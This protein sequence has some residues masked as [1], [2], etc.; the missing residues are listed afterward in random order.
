MIARQ[1]I[2]PDFITVQELWD[3]REGLLKGFEKFEPDILTG[4][5]GL[6]RI[7]R[8]RFG[9][10][11]VLQGDSS[12]NLSLL[13]CVKATMP[14]PLGPDSDVICVDGG[15]I[16]DAYLISKHSIEQGLDSEK[17]LERIHLS[18][19]FT[20][21]QLTLLLTEKLPSAMDVY[22]AKL[23]IVSDMA[24][25]YCDPDIRGAD[26]LDALRIFTNTVR[27]LRTLA[28][29]KHAIILATSLQ[30]RNQRMN[31]ILFRSAHLS[32]KLEDRDTFTELNVIRHPS[33]PRMKTLVSKPGVQS[34]E[35]YL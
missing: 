27:F 1:E 26:K 25:L 28:E 8:L 19:A 35:R 16:F 12:H 13:L 17:V 15:N 30:A 18:R 20:Y 33:L 6:D 11:V 22:A 10:F 4:M 3:R 2:K 32:A 29:Q 5:E 24:Q 7:L 21:H 14:E 23:V 34:L 31:R 9:Q